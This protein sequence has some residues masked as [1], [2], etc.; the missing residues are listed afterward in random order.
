MVRAIG[1][2][3]FPQNYRLDVPPAPAR[4]KTGSRGAMLVAEWLPLAALAADAAPWHDLIGRA[5]EPNVFLEPEFARAALAADLGGAEIGV[6][7]VRADTRLVGLLPGRVE[8]LAFA[9]PMPVFV[10]WTHSF[11]PLSTPLVDRKGA[12]DIVAAMLDYLPWL[13]GAPRVALFPLIAEGPVT[14][15]ILRGGRIARF[16]VH[17]RAVLKPGKNA[18]PAASSGKLKELRRQ[19]R[20]LAEL[21]EIA[22]ETAKTARDVEDALG[23]YL[24]VEAASWKGRAGSAAMSDP[25]AA[26]FL[27]QAVT[28]LA[29][30]GK[31]RIDLFTLDGRAI[32][33][34][35]TLFAGNRAWFWKTAYDESYARFSPGVQ[36]ALDLTKSLANEK[37]IALADSCAVADHPM[38]DHLW[39]G[40]VEMADWLVPLGGR[41][42]FAAAIA[43]EHARRAV[44]AGVKV[45]RD[46]LRPGQA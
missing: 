36:L 41:A 21:G 27:M 22:F 3:S 10:A 23:R 37:G 26:Q 38:I 45:L 12:A 16:G 13:P 32:A 25:Q 30:E 5:L 15:A 11:A 24:Q 44:V 31:A 46:R 39:S 33:S 35:I 1:S 19:R 9:Q 17:Q 42:S 40:R 18:K 6:V 14:Q 43:A 4:A 34:T 2:S 8:G 20:R 29:S 7:T 28:G